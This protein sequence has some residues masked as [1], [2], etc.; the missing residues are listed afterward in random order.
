MDSI[1]AANFNFITENSTLKILE[2]RI[3][4]LITARSMHIHRFVWMQYDVYQEIQ[5]VRPL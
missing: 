4:R 5:N 3:I 2:P 1:I